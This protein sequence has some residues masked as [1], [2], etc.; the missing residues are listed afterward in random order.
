[1]AS[2]LNL[3][4]WG[5]AF[6]ASLLWLPLYSFDQHDNATGLQMMLLIRGSD[7]E[8]EE[9]LVEVSSLFGGFSFEDRPSAF[10]EEGILPVV[11]SSSKAGVSWNAGRK[12]LGDLMIPYSVS[13]SSSDQ[14]KSDS[15]IVRLHR[16]QG[17][18]LGSGF[19]FMASPPPADAYQISVAW[20]LSRAPKKTR[21]VWTYREGPWSIFQN[22]PASILRDSVYMVGQIHSNSP[23]PTDGGV[24]GYYGYYC[25]ANSS[26]QHLHRLTAIG[27]SFATVGIRNALIW[28]GPS[29]MDLKVDWLYE[30]IRDCQSIYMPFGHSSHSGSYDQATINMLCIKYY[31]NPLTQRNSELPNIMTLATRMPTQENTSPPEPGHSLS[32]LS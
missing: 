29:S 7:V 6:A 19:A 13:A 15:P 10:D 21:E 9:L 24:S 12:T 32:E 3:Y 23:A 1:M 20:D 14:F 31:T 2:S 25:Y 18:L 8:E 26:R 27:V 28:L 22:G 11:M 17:G 5:E 30:G 16:D 4:V